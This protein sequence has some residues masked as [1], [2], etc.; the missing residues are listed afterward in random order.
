VSKRIKEE[1]ENGKEYYQF[2]GKDL[3]IL[4]NKIADRPSNSF[5]DWHNLNKYKE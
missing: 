1:Y 3:L 5:I 2:H 4:P